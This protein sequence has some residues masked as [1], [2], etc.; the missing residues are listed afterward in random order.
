MNYAS[1]VQA[2]HHNES[3]V[4]KH[5]FTVDRTS[6]FLIGGHRPAERLFV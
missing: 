6:A 3:F 1:C 4:T 5:F 2:S